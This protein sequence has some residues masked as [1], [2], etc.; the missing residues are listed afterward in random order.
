[1]MFI[2]GAVSVL[3]IL[4]AAFWLLMPKF[5]TL[6]FVNN[7][8]RWSFEETVK[9]IADACKERDD[10]VIQGEK[11]F[12]ESYRKNGHQELPHRIYEFKLGN[13]F[14][15][16]AVNEA[17]PAV[18]TFMPASIAV[19]EFEPDHVVIYRKNTALMGRMFQNPVRKIMNIEVPQQLDELLRDVIA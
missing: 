15:S 8:S 10:W 16:R 18:C 9:R 6:F 17:F 12:N 1:M 13:P 7:R 2:L 5:G 14:H 4:G 11:D 19:V 3:L